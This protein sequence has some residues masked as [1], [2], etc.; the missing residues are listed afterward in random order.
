MPNLE[1]RNIPDAFSNH[2]K[3]DEQLKHW[4]L[5]NKTIKKKADSGVFVAASYLK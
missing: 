3:P 4:G 1:N 5:W 2:L